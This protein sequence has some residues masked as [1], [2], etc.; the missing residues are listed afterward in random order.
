MLV[1]PLTF[2]ETE[3]EENTLPEV[4]HLVSE[5]PR[6]QTQARVLVPAVV[7][8]LKTIIG[9]KCGARRALQVL[10]TWPS[11]SSH[12]CRVVGVEC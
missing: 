3:T 1:F 12:Y 6:T 4:M 5:R 10:R 9:H 11:P 2:E 7:I 8:L